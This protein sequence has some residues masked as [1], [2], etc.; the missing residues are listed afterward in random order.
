LPA[1]P[2]ERA[3]SNGIADTVEIQLN[4]EIPGP[5]QHSSSQP[6]QPRPETR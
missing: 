3:G 4:T 2:P 6:H 5:G 1:R